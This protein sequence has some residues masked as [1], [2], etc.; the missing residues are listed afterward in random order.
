ENAIYIILLIYAGTL[1]RFDNS[2]VL[3]FGLAL[4]LIFRFLIKYF[5]GWVAYKLCVDK[6]KFNQNI[7]SGLFPQGLISFS[8]VI[9]FQQMYMSSLT[10]TIFAI[11]L[12]ASLISEVISNKILKDLLIDYNEI[13]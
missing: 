1:I 12:F 5:N 8:I 11:I 7:G 9:S 4:Y 10:H 3:L 13:K 6:T 2:L